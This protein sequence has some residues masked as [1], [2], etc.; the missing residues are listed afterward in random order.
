VPTKESGGR[1]VK[2]KRGAEARERPPSGPISTPRYTPPKPKTAR[3]SNLWVP[4][5]M[6][7]CFAL[8]V[9]VIV[10]NYL[11]VL[12][13]GNA[14]NEYLFVGLANLIAGFVLS[15]TYR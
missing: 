15:T 3:R 14:M 13:G 5:L 1:R 2:I 11:E 12:P 8:G 7:T 9:I 10:A 6:F 4:V